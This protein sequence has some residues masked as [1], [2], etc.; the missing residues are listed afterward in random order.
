MISFSFIREYPFSRQPHRQTADR[1]GRF[2]AQQAARAAT[3]AF[4]LVGGVQPH[5]GPG[6]AGADRAGSSGDKEKAR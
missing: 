2:R 4:L 1:A 5:S 6:A 3:R